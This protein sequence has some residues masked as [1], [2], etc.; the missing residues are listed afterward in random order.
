MSRQYQAW[1]REWGRYGT[2]FYV[3]LNYWFPVY[4]A[5]PLAGQTAGLGVSYSLSHWKFGV[6]LIPLRGN[7]RPLPLAFQAS[8]SISKVK[9]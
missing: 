4:Q 9:G 5:G 3:R 8:N 7:K 1:Y 6:L 2:W